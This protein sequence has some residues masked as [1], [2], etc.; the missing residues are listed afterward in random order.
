MS[1]DGV[2]GWALNL[3]VWPLRCPPVSYHQTGDL[4]ELACAMFLPEWSRLS[5]FRFPGDS[6]SPRGSQGQTD[7]VTN[8]SL[9][10]VLRAEVTRSPARLAEQS[11]LTACLPASGPQPYE[12][13]GYE[14]VDKP[15]DSFDLFPLLQEATGRAVSSRTPA[16]RW[17]CHRLC[18]AVTPRLPRSASYPCVCASQCD[19]QPKPTGKGDYI[20][21]IVTSCCQAVNRTSS[22]GCEDR[23]YETV[24]PTPLFSGGAGPRSDPNSVS[25]RF[26]GQ[27]F[28]ARALE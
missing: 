13:L 8:S 7:P 17:A 21:A 24:D 6:L 4:L 27:A 2:L 9:S 15:A 20:A 28:A 26:P 18:E 5:I 1:P 23:P 14:R 25:S 11:L 3:A 22:G 16:S 19:Q 12:V 10:P